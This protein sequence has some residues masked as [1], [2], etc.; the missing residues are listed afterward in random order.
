MFAYCSRDAHN[1]HFSHT[2]TLGVPQRG[3]NP[4]TDGCVHAAV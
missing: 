3:E 4:G 2:E 1:P